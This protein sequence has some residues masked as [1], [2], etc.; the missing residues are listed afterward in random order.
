MWRAAQLAWLLLAVLF[1]NAPV[2]EGA[3]PGTELEIAE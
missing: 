3:A 1:V 2:R